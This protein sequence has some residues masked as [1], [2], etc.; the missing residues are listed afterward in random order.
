MQSLIDH[1]RAFSTSAPQSTGELSALELGQSPEV[2]FITCSDSR[3]VPTLFTGTRPGDLFEL[4]TAGNIVP[5]YSTEHPSGEMAT[6]EYAVQVLG[7]RDI[8]VCGHSHCGAVGALVRDEDLTQLPAVQG[9]L[10]RGASAGLMGDDEGHAPDVA[11]PVQRHALAQLDRL[12]EYPCVAERLADGRLG[13]HAWYYE[14]HTGAV[15][16]HR[17]DGDEAAFLP[18]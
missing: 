6:V 17:T 7:V 9:W 12:R 8:I 2:L 11:A 13:L 15:L 10:A 1:A 4:R 18:L 16:A 3:V 14:V 5:A